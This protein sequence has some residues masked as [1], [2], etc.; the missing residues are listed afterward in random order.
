[1]S[2]LY[3]GPPGITA[4]KLIEGCMDESLTAINRTLNT[5]AARVFALLEVAAA[6]DRAQTAISSAMIRAAG[7]IST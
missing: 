3:D 1:M 5:R 2:G 4:R 7:R 6:I